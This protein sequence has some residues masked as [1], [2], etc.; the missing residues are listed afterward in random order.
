MAEQNGRGGSTVEQILKVLLGQLQSISKAETVTGQPIV[1]DKTTII[2]ISKVVIGFAAG[3]SDAGGQ[4]N[5]DSRRGNISVGGTGGGI[6]VEPVG[7]IVVPPEGK[8]PQLLPMKGTINQ[9]AR[10]IDLVPDVVAKLASM[11]AGSAA[12]VADPAT[13]ELEAQRPRLPSK[14]ET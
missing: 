7:F 10:V 8:P 9:L 1:A 3:G 11:R 14:D 12:S 6:S 13:A 4:V 2:P 5:G